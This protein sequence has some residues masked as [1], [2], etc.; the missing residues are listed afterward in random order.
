MTIDETTAAETAQNIDVHQLAASRLAVTDQR[1]TKTRR[2][3]VDALHASEGPLTIAGILV[4][5][6]ELAQS[7]TYRNL[8]VLEEAAV[9][10]RIV[11]SDDF[12]RFE[13]TEDVTGYHHHHLIC[14][15]CGAIIDINLP[16][17]LE[18][19]LDKALS[20]QARNVDFTGTHHRVDLVGLCS[21]CH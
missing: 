7:S 16:R 18:Q 14:E 19:Q 20:D 17:S 5:S 10:Q 1:Y 12:A 13:L 21:D 4:F 3:I 8:A 9:V 6:D 11:V 15:G 2:T